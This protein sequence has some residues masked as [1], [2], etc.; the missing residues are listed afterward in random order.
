VSRPCPGQNNGSSPLGRFLKLPPRSESIDARAKRLSNSI[1]KA[2]ADG[3]DMSEIGLMPDITQRT[4][5]VSRGSA[6][7]SGRGGRRFK[8]C[9]SD[10]TSSILKLRPELFTEFF[11]RFLAGSIM[12]FSGPARSSESITRQ[13]GGS[14]DHA[15][16]RINRAE[17]RRLPL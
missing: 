10:Q 13:H 15:E 7:R 14:G 4:V 3:R 12:I 1:A 6:P 9:H 5:K 11:V 8:S 16:H 17:R 2:L